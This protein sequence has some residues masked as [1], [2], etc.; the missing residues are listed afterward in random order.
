MF[1]VNN[2]V[3]AESLE[4]AYELNQNKN[5]AILGGILW[6]KMGNRT[7]DTAIDL[8]ALQLNKIEEFDDS[9]KIGCMCTLRD[10]ETHKGLNVY[11][12]GFLASAVEHIVGVQFR[13]SATVGGS[14]Y[15]RFAFSDVITALLAL[16]TSVEIYK[17]GIIS[18][19]EYMN[20]P[21]DRNIVVRI[22]IMKNHR[23]AVYLSHR[24]SAMDFSTLSCA[25]S[26]D[27]N[28][29]N[30]VLGARPDKAKKVEF[31]LSAKPDAKEI[32]A[33]IRE[34]IEKIEFGTNYRGSREY[35][36]IL[37]QVLIL[38]GIEIILFEGNYAN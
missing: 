31:K 22:V 25:V 36:K 17:G 12:N 32:E 26:N 19:E 1:T 13:N 23:K 9:F 15:S 30:I 28:H 33:L 38:K 2:Y 37:A 21:H 18:L 16:D 35:R 7:I 34:T 29:W 8:S 11:F 10:I 20:M 24:T 5:N 6:L 14:I 27:H 4:Q 3:I